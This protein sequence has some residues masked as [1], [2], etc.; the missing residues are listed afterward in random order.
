MKQL[1]FAAA[2]LLA[3]CASAGA[4]EQNDTVAALASAHVRECPTDRTQANARS[5]GFPVPQ[6]NPPMHRIAVQSGVE[7]VDVALTPLAHGSTRAVRLRLLIV[8]RGGIIGWHDHT[9]VQG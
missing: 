6:A 8:Q 2:A 9:Q 5:E 1:W 3:A 7:T 4:Q